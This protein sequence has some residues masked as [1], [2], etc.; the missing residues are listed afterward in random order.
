MAD[1]HSA[2]VAFLLFLILVVII[3]YLL[4]VPSEIRAA[5]LGM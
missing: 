1:K 2:I 5:I 3:A 4:A